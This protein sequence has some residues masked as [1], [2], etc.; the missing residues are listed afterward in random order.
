MPRQLVKRTL[1]Y[2]MSIGNKKMHVFNFYFPYI[3]TV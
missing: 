2:N 3:E 1:D